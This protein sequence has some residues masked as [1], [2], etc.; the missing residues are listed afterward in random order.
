M[1]TILFFFLVIGIS[2]LTLQGIDVSVYQKS[3]N[4]PVVAQNKH[5]AII[6]AGYGNNGIDTYWETNYK[7]AKNAGVKIGAYWYSYAASVDDAKSEA[8]A[9]V[10]ALRGKKF[11]WPVYYDI[12]EDSIFKANLQDKIAKAFCDILESN[13]YY[14]GIYT[15]AYVLNHN[16]NAETKRRY[17][18]WVAHWD[19]SKPSYN[20]N[21]DVWQ[22]KV[23]TSPGISGACD[24]DE[25]YTNFE[26]IMKQN[27]LNGY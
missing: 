24:L 19:V 18:I 6:R 4:W 11:E 12:E 8:N 22:K 21:Y 3:I 13:K 25:G 9:F 20:G 15:G 27:H 23:G 17:T 7:G 26:P 14:C 16:F 2:S 5:F 10:K 1:K